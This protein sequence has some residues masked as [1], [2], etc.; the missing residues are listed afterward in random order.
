MRYNRFTLNNKVLPQPKNNREWYLY[1]L[2]N[3]LAFIEERDKIIIEMESLVGQKKFGIMLLLMSGESLCS[4]LKRRIPRSLSELYQ[5]KLEQPNPNNVE[6]KIIQRIEDLGKK[7]GISTNS[8]EQGLKYT[9]ILAPLLFKRFPRINIEDGMVVIRLDGTMKLKDIRN[10]YKYIESLLKQLPD[11][12]ERNNFKI[13][14]DLIY[15]IRKQL[16]AGM[17]FE[18][19]NVLY[20]AGNLPGYKGMATIHGKEELA[21]YYTRSMADFVKTI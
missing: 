21:K 1:Y 16:L 11:Y 13:R 18:D 19:I 20:E 12:K 5:I 8:V 9:N 14:P 4:Q 10:A 2:Y 3:D 15:A 7:F 6:T 17:T